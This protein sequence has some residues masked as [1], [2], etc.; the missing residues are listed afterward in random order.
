MRSKLC[1][2]QLL[3]KLLFICADILIGM[4]TK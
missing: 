4:R 1:P 2:N 3:N